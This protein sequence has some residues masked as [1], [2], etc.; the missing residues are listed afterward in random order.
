M[1]LSG[2]VVISFFLDFEF[3]KNIVTKR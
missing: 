2:E 1:L 3:L